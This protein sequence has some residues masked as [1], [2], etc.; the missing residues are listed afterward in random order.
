MVNQAHGAHTNQAAV[1]GTTFGCQ[2]CHSG[3]D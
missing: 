2:T 3:D 1:Y